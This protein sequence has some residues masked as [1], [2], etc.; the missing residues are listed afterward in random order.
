MTATI[1]C[2]A[3][4]EGLHGLEARRHGV[5]TAAGGDCFVRFFGTTKQSGGIA[6]SASA[7][8]AA[9]RTAR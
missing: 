6:T 7:S 8:A 2:A 4:S 1:S 5:T 3:E 9:A